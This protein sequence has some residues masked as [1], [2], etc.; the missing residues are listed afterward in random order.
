MVS[1]IWENSS[2]GSRSSGEDMLTAVASV[3]GD[4]VYMDDCGG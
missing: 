1:Q 3:L 4:M 2:E